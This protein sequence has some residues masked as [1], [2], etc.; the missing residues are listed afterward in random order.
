MLNRNAT[1]R[2]LTIVEL[3][4][5][6]VMIGIIASILIVSI[7]HGLERSKQNSAMAD[8]RMIATA[9]EAYA[10]DTNMLPNDSQGLEAIA[11]ELAPH[12]KGA[13]IPIYDY[14]AHPYSYRHDGAGNYTL[15]SFGKDGIDG[16]NWDGWKHTEYTHDIV[17]YNGVFV[18]AP[19]E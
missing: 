2:G 9:I 10:V 16:D 18:N 1:Q 17:L 14:W 12:N 13:S 6:M 19:V 11:A 4:V 5:V 15:E 7:T 3:L 8:I